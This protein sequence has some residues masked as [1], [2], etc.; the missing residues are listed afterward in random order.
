MRTIYSV[1]RE[2]VDRHGNKTALIYKYGAQYE[3]ITYRNL[4]DSINCFSEKLQL[5]GVQKDD[6]VGILSSNRPEWVITDLATIKLG[7]VLVPVYET[8]SS[9]EIK[10][11][12]DD[13]QVKVLIVEG[14]YLDKVRKVQIEVPTLIKIIAIN[15]ENLAPN[16]E[17]FT[18]ST[19]KGKI[20]D[21]ASDI[22][23]E[24]ATIVYTSG[25]TGK[26]KGVML[27]QENIITNALALIERGQ[28]TA[29]DILLSFLPLSHMYERTVGYYA[30]LFAGA[31][32]A[33]AE[34][35]NTIAINMQ[36]IR[37][38]IV[39]VVPRL[40]EKMY[41]KI[42]ATIHTSSKIKKALFLAAVKNKN[43][44]R[45]LRANNKKIPHVLNFKCKLL[46]MLVCRKVRR[47]VGGR[48]RFFTSGGASLKKDINIFYDDFGIPILEGYGLTETSPVLTSNSQNDYKIGSAGKPLPNVKIKINEANSEILAK[49]LGVMLGYF[50]NK[51]ATDEAID[52]E[53][54]FH[55]GDIGSLDEE[56]YLTI[57]GRLK[58][59]LITSYGQ[60]ISPVYVEEQLLN[61]RFIDQVMIYGDGEKYLSAFI[62][63]G[64]EQLKRQFLLQE[65]INWPKIF[66]SDDIHQFI[67]TE[68][69]KK[70]V[71]LARYEKIKNFILLEEAFSVENGLLTPTL[72][73]KRKEVLKRYSEKVK[74]N[75]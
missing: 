31:A 63:P 34:N 22:K 71:N 61:S 7:A 35:I 15:K 24:L 72:K 20:P 54:W 14:E 62:V 44:Y 59:L 66:E 52:A 45:E 25:T 4:Y 38:T 11:I 57:A 50:R 33:Y 26:P 69:E 17:L 48:L 12:L 16:E 41:E 23:N 51:Q 42:W 8:L 1:F 37:P 9:S 47:K 64:K 32:I 30:P 40:L 2:V 13:A 55:T 39:N 19:R 27:S 43:T 46:D 49:G 58:E 74:G 10:Y 29:Q 75:K 5:W 6:K 21:K 65:P 53:G 68:I 73:I 60:K 18:C 36:E 3:E 67:N 56:G 28:V 70:S